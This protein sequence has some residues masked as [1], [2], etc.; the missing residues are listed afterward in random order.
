MCLLL[1]RL[2]RLIR[3]SLGTLSAVTAPFSF[4]RR[5]RL[6]FR[7]KVVLILK[8]KAHFGRLQCGRWGLSDQVSP[9][10]SDDLSA[11]VTEDKH[12]ISFTRL[13]MCTDNVFRGLVSSTEALFVY[14]YQHAKQIPSQR[15]SVSGGRNEFD[16]LHATQQKGSK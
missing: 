11:P 9:G 6:G 2:L 15:G 14:F 5:L 13:D 3:M 12:P 1:I 16:R 8:S 10:E 7:L 4:S